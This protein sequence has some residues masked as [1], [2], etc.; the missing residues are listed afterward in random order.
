MFCALLGV[1]V[2]DVY[3]QQLQDFHCFVGSPGKFIKEKNL[4][5]HLLHDVHSIMK[6]WESQMLLPGS[7]IWTHWCLMKC[8]S[9]STL[10]VSRVLP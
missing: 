3:T 4:R 9:P 2:Q 7:I 8:C 1:A 10:L 5:A 6:I